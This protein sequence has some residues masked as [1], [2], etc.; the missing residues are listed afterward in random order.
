MNMYSVSYD[1]IAPGKDYAP[2]W[3]RLRE[4]GAVRVLESQWVFRNAARVGAVR[5]DIARYIDAN[6][7]LLVIDATN[8]QFA[9]QNLKADIKVALGLTSIA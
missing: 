1:L 5:D 9:W 2:L 3:A 4:L 7:R 8:G 6:D